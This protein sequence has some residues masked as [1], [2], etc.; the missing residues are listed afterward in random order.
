MD[1]ISIVGRVQDAKESNPQNG[2]SQTIPDDD[3]GDDG[4]GNFQGNHWILSRE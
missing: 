3:R 4:N 1:Q 2:L